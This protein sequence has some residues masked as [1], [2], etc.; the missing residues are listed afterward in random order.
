M[1]GRGGAAPDGGGRRTP[2]VLPVAIVLILCSLTV[3][4]CQ[5][6]FVPEANAKQIDPSEPEENESWRRI[7]ED[8][9]SDEQDCMRR[10]L[11]PFL[12]PLLHTDVSLEV[13]IE[14]PAAQLFA[15]L[16]PESAHSVFMAA[17]IKYLQQEFGP[18]LDA[19]VEDCWRQSLS[20]DDVWGAFVYE[21]VGVN[22]GGPP[23]SSFQKAVSSSRRP[24]LAQR[25]LFQRMAECAP[26]LIVEAAA[27][28]FSLASADL[29]NTELDCISEQVGDLDVTAVIAPDRE[30]VPG[31]VL[32]AYLLGDCAPQLF[33]SQLFDLAG[34]EPISL[35]AAQVDCAHQ[36]M[37]NIDPSAAAVNLRRLGHR[38]TL[39]LLWFLMSPCWPDHISTARD[40]DPVYDRVIRRSDTRVI[41]GETVEDALEGMPDVDWFDFE[42]NAGAHYTIDL[43]VAN[44][45]P[46]YG[47]LYL[48]DPGTNE[49]AQPSVNEHA[50]FSVHRLIVKV[51]ETDHYRLQVG[52]HAYGLTPYTLSIHEVHIEDDHSNTQA[53]AALAT[54][55]EVI[56]GELEFDFDTD[57][58]VFD[59]VAGASYLIDTSL[60]SLHWSTLRLES[61]DGE[62]LKQD[63]N[64][65]EP[66][67]ARIAWTAST[68]DRYVVKL[69]GVGRGTYSIVIW[70][71]ADD[72]SGSVTA[73]TAIAGGGQVQ[74]E[75]NYPRDRDVFAFDAVKGVFYDISVNLESLLDSYLTVGRNDDSVETRSDD[76]GQSLAS[77][78]V[79]QAE[80]SRQYFIGVSGRG[81]GTYSLNVTRIEINDDH[82]GTEDEATV[83]QL[84][85][86][87]QGKVD[88]PDDRDG[89]VFYGE[90]GETYNI[91]IRLGTLPG[92]NLDVSTIVE[93]PGEI[94]TSSG[95]WYEGPRFEPARANLVEWTP[96]LSGKQFISLGGHGDGT[97]ELIVTIA[98]SVSTAVK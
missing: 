37:S 17:S 44:D 5:S 25:M 45:R 68:S 75:I 28:R 55:G 15:C 93:C 35:D 62:L 24:G 56:G 11:G 86:V 82:S 46:F 34:A 71:P 94:C 7:V 88:Y 77:R 76:Y 95:S 69:G 2:L 22:P 49:R 21:A 59:A 8:A 51:P 85:E 31:L 67:S 36:L 4:A 60:Q 80:E 70:Q 57:V 40:A 63:D 65:G 6:A 61:A 13:R 54:L 18:S 66:G 64:Y 96:D 42:G 91:V 84:G 81:T 73:A 19:G 1:F 23:P 43:R 3:V 74:G 20:A 29:T 27:G 53:G 12:E 47:T 50:G 10:S 26:G 14:N 98:S 16:T 30:H 89:F 38:Q 39:S 33:V 41:V 48:L 97:Y 78:V 32:A 52:G 9:S 90:A 58:F 83:L 72:H 79:W 92:V 87:V